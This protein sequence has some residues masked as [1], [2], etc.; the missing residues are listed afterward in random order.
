MIMCECYINGLF[1]SRQVDRKKTTNSTDADRL[2]TVSAA[3]SLK[4]KA[5][6]VQI[7]ESHQ[8]LFWSGAVYRR[9]ESSEMTD[10]SSLLLIS[11]DLH[12]RVVLFCW[13][14]TGAGWGNGLYMNETENQNQ[15]LW[16]RTWWRVEPVC[17]QRSEGS[18][19]SLPPGRLDEPR[20]PA[21]GSTGQAET[22]VVK[23]SDSVTIKTTGGASSS[24]PLVSVVNTE[25]T[26]FWWLF[27]PSLSR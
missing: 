26:F 15:T 19:T 16:T 22:Q 1:H 17:V 25:N 6:W 9:E 13:L 27:S 11:L 10:L 14:L 4:M 24:D 5:S 7:L 18:E 2:T 12:R 3:G 23:H 21:A 8:I 20:Q